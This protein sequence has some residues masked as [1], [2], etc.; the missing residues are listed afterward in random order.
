VTRSILVFGAGGQVGRELLTRAR[1]EAVPATGAARSD[2]DI[3]DLDAVLKLARAAKPRMI[4]NAAAYTAV[5]RAET[6]ASAAYAVNALGAENV[7]RAATE[8]GADLLHI[9]TDY[10]FDGRK[11]GPYTESDPVAPIGVY[12]ASKADG[13]SRVLSIMPHAVILRTAWVYG[14]YGNNFLKTMLRLAVTQPK[15]RVV[16]D[17]CGCPTATVDIAA[18][19]LAV[20]NSATLSGGIFHFAGTGTTS[21]HGF[22]EAIVDAQAPFSGKRP[23]VEAIGTGQYPTAARRPTNSVLQSDRFVRTFGYRSQP[24]QERTRETVEA[25]LKT[26]SE[27]H[28]SGARR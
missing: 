2:A 12:G 22:A 21:W 5:D 19:I 3:T 14:R 10:V 11:A 6:D 1:A 15:L 17:Q 26:N 20:A 28:S 13:E 4:V 8:I 18:A 7:A 16:A 23:P 9:S 27:T 25:F 24:W